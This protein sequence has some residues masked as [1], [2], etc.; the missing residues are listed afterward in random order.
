[1][2]ITLDALGTLVEL[3][4]PAPL[5]AGELVARGVQASERQAGAA[6]AAE[7]AFYRAHHDGAP[8]AASL[9]ALRERCAGVLRDALARAGVDSAPLSPA[10]LLGALLASLRFRAYPEVPD[11]LRA[12]RAAGHRLVVVS[13]WDVSLHET[14]RATGIAP[15]L[16][17]AISSAEAGAAKPDARIFRRARELAGGHRRDGGMH[18]GDSLEHDVAGALKAGL[19]PVLVARGGRPPA[20][21][22]S[23][24]VIASLAELEDL[25][26]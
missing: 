22:A 13:N 4:E 1:M 25:A 17:G 23:V 8:D 19:R 24:T 18:A 2:I 21:P 6:L 10:E 11:A 26:A 5:L 20:A 14:L 15:L 16:H 3:Q 7:I 12:L 9:A